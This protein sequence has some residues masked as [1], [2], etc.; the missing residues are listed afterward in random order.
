[1]EDG[2]NGENEKKK[3]KM[4]WWEDRNKEMPVEIER[5]KRASKNEGKETLE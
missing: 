3:E 5:A 1:M 4:H 2:R